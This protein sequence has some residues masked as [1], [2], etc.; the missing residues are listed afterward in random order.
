MS[1]GSWTGL[2]HSV[3]IQD[4]SGQRNYHQEKNIEGDKEHTEYSMLL[5]MVLKSCRLLELDTVRTSID[6]HI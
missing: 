3:T 6:N 5:M 4:Q 1:G 2:N